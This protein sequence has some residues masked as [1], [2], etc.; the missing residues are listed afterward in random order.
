MPTVGDDLNTAQRKLHDAAIIGQDGL[1]WSRAELLD[2]YNEGYTQL[3]AL[4]HAT[5]RFT[6]MEVPPR[7]TATGS[8]A[9]MARFADGGSF[10]QWAHQAEG[11]WA[12]SSL[13]QIETLEGLNSTPTAAAN[14]MTQPWM[15]A[16]DN[17]TNAH[18]RFAL[19]RDNERIVKIWYDNKLLI[20]LATRRLDDLYTNW[21]SIEGEPLVWTMGTGRNRTF[22]VYNVVT[23]ITD[24]FEA[25]DD[26]T[27]DRYPQHGIMRRLTGDR[28]Y[29]WKSVDASEPVGIP[30]RIISQDRQYYARTDAPLRHPFGRGYRLASSTNALLVLDA[31]VPDVGMLTEDDEAAL[32]PRQLQ[33]YLRY[34]T[35]FRAFNRQGEGYNPNMAAFY[36]RRF[37]R[38]VAFLRSLN[39]L[40]RRD[41]RMA[42][43]MRRRTERRPRRPQ[44]PADY[45]R[46]YR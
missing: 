24:T 9:W 2:W 30:R 3:L 35:Y 19:P 5:R 40:A 17:D 25:V 29:D 15:R 11:D 12:V 28:T 23:T 41:S 18:F 45:P 42:R 43:D 26:V 14:N 7:Y 22:E 37:G 4:T 32:V 27:N 20:P 21:Y 44:F 1:I 10:A 16:F 13:W 46:V 8:Q 6:A 39:M 31:H 33:K 34:F 36:E 38:G